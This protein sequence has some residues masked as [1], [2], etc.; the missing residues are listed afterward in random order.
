MK[1]VGIPICHNSAFPQI[2]II[3][4]IILEKEGGQGVIRNLC[5]LLK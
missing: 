1:I 5:E 4:R 2:K 3:S